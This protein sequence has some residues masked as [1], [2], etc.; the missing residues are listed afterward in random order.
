MEMKKALKAYARTPL[1]LLS[2]F[3]S[4][5]AGALVT[6]LAGA[7]IPFGLAGGFVFW[8]GFSFA[9]LQTGAG[10]KAIVAQAESEERARTLAFIGE[11]EAFL[12]RLE[13]IRL[14]GG[15]A[16]TALAFLVQSAGEYLG[17]CRKTLSRSPEADARIADSLDLVDLY[18]REL[19]D[20][21]T[22]RR[23][24]APDA[25]AFEDSGKRVI[26][27]IRDN[28]LFIRGERTKLDGGLPPAE[29]MAIMEELK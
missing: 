21:S 16:A 12:K 15:E 19:D 2:L 27:S 23:F 28:A 5:G 6:G 20:T 22:E 10:A 14:P 25:E 13:V 18:L 24:G 8:I 29:R 11:T 7:F 3:A 26:A 17:A 4:L 9:L 1:A